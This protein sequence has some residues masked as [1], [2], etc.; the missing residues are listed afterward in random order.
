MDEI[1][2]PDRYKY[3]VWNQEKQKYLTN[4]EITIETQGSANNVYELMAH[5]LDSPDEYLFEHCTSLRDRK[6]QLIY[7]GDIIQTTTGK[8]RFVVEW[9]ESDGCFVFHRLDNTD[10]GSLNVSIAGILTGDIEVIGNVHE[11]S[12]SNINNEK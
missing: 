2:I 5:Y 11:C 1:N 8:L 4:A 7:E 6:N 12:N 9:N 10:N 3:R